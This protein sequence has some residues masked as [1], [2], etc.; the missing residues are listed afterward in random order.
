[1]PGEPPQPIRYDVE[2]A[3]EN[4]DLP[5]CSKDILFALARRI[6]KDSIIIP[7]QFSP[8]LYRLAEA[9]GW[10]K[11]NLQRH[12][13][14]LEQDGLLVR[15]RWKGRRTAYAIVWPRLAEL[16]TQWLRKRAEARAKRSLPPET[17][18]PDTGDM[19]APGLGT[20]KARTGDTGAPSQTIQ[21]VSDQ[22]PDPEIAMIARLLETRTGK[23]VTDEWAAATRD[24][25]L[26]AAGAPPEPGPARSSYIRR[27]IIHDPQP[28]RWLPTPQPPRYQREE[29]K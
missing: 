20:G 12:L 17:P 2:R 22:E 27:I 5:T 28:Q 13:N 25:I 10:S 1:M 19:A 3:A 24:A 29:G 16:E 18:G 15:I 14:R 26:G 8:S 11:R 9:T 6:E 21:T 23:A 4:T 7:R